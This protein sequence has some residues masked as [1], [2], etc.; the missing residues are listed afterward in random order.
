MKT[1]IK[2]VKIEHGA[3]VKLFASR[4][5]ESRMSAGLSQADLAKRAGSTASYLGRLERAEREPGIDLAL[6]LAR[7]L[8]VSLADLLPLSKSGRIPLLKEQAKEHFEQIL[9][10]DD[11]PALAILNTWLA[12]LAESVTKRV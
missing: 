2:N 9:A 4:L 3:P 7:A 12:L 6:R 5:R 1:R 10:T 11:E 8:G